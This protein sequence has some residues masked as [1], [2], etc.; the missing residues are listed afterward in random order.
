MSQCAKQ[1]MKMDRRVFLKTAGVGG[2]M[3]PNLA[4]NAGAREDQDEKHAGE[5]KRGPRPSVSTAVRVLLR[6]RR[7]SRR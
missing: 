5:K 3:L 4:G 1:C 6:W 7:Q 2:V